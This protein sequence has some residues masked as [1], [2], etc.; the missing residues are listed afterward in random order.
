[1]RN[2]LL[3]LM[4]IASVLLDTA[5]VQQRECAVIHNSGSTNTA[6]YTISVWPDA[7]GQ[8]LASGTP[9]KQISL[10][11]DLASRFFADLR[12]AQ[13]D[14]GV[15]QHCMKSA[16]FGTSTVVEWHGWKSPDLQC[17]PFSHS[18]GA[19]ATDVRDIQSAADIRLGTIHRIHLPGD[20]RMIP[21]ATPEVQPT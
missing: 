17:P 12:A 3:L 11:K 10:P 7:T 18:V 6:A 2:G 4:A 8:V 15:P 13:S 16:S 9:S 21:T 5:A 1:M 20:V 14:P 19:L